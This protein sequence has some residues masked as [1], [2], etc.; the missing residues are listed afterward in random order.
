MTRIALPA[1]LL[2]AGLSVAAPAANAAEIKVLTGGAYDQVLQALVPEFEKQ[3]GH[4]VKSEKAPAGTLKKRIESGEAFDVADHHS[5]RD[6]RVDQGRQARCA[7]LRQGRH[8]WCRRR[9]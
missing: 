9:R 1:A 5:G 3:T 4:T 7:K 2:L 6:G 8:R